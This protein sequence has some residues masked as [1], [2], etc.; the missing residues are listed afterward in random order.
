MRLSCC[1]SMFYSYDEY[2]ESFALRLENV[3]QFNY[4]HV[5]CLSKKLKYTFL[6]NSTEFVIAMTPD[7]QC[8]FYKI[9]LKKLIYK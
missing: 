3:Y 5:Q 7:K 8:I 9:I 1:P 4:L 2:E 6:P